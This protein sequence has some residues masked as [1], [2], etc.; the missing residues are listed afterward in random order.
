[1]CGAEHMEPGVTAAACT[2]DC[3]AKGTKY[4]L[5]VGNKVYTLEGENE[6]A[7]GQLNKLAGKEAQ[8]TGAV[9][10]GDIIEVVSVDAAK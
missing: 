3:V 1:M 7:L 2:K 8:V 5:V 10:P 4:A 9:I 6:S